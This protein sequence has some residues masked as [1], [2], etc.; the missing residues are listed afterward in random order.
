MA[1]FKEWYQTLEGK[2]T[3]ELFSEVRG[4]IF[5]GGETITVAVTPTGLLSGI[6]KESL[7]KYNVRALRGRYAEHKTEFWELH[8]ALLEKIAAM[9][10][11]GS[12]LTQVATD[13]HVP[14]IVLERISG[15]TA[16]PTSNRQILARE[17]TKQISEIESWIKSVMPSLS[18]EVSL[19]IPGHAVRFDS[20]GPIIMV[21]GV[22]SVHELPGGVPEEVSTR[23]LLQLNTDWPMI[24]KKIQAFI[25]ALG[26]LAPMIQK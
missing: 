23:D 2:A 13:K 12:I 6:D 9:E 24:R 7:E 22:L 10:L 14:G 5:V 3:S 16:V 4:S 11:A 19:K 8:A 21:D 26:K 18:L 25:R 17:L 15:N 20:S 1:T